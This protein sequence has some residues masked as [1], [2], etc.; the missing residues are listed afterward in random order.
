M[1]RKLDVMEFVEEL[2]ESTGARLNL[3]L[4]VF[5]TPPSPFPDIEG[6]G[7]R[8]RIDPTVLSSEDEDRIRDF[9]ERRGLMTEDYWNDWG[10]Y[11]TI[12]KKKV[13]PMSG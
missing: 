2:R 1:M 5:A 6:E 13:A 9:A 8:L 4:N 3:G 7:Y 10:R 12:W 11:L